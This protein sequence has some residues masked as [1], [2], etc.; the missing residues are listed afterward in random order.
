MQGRVTGSHG[1]CPCQVGWGDNHGFFKKFGKWTQY[2]AHGILVQ[3]PIFSING[4]TW[5]MYIEWQRLFSLWANIPQF[6]DLFLD[7]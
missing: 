6:H 7:V 4:L 5:M 2:Q 1:I 3:M